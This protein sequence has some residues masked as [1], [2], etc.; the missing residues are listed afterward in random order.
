MALDAQVRSQLATLVREHGYERRQEPF[1]LTSGGWSHDYIDGK[2]AV[3]GGAQLRLVCQ[4][5]IDIVA[6]PFDAVGGPTMG[7]DAMAHGVALLSGAAWFSVRKEP[8]GHGRQA[9]VEGT[10]LAPGDRVVFVEDVSST[11]ASLLR[12]ID[13]VLELG[14]VPVAAV[15][16]LDRSPVVARRFAEKGI[17]YQPLL[18]WAEIGIDPLSE[19]G[20]PAAV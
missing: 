10:R 13:R 3:A 5:V 16:L 18:T 20:T 9:W 4:A 12:A 14:V 19:E 17:R 1:Q 15:T 6:E 2:H 11:G 8:K 7:A